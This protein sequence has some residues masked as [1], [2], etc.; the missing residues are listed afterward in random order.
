MTA[1]H[2]WINVPLAMLD[3]TCIPCLLYDVVYR[4]GCVRCSTEKGFSFSPPQWGSHVRHWRD[5]IPNNRNKAGTTPSAVQSAG[6]TSLTVWTSELA[7]VS[8]PA[9]KRS[10][11]KSNAQRTVA[12]QQR[13]SSKLQPDPAN[14][15]PRLESESRNLP[16]ADDKTQKGIF[17]LGAKKSRIRSI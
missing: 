6:R 8:C 7:S 16:F 10:R 4:S 1:G 13:W 5:S 2:G 3:K 12:D 15:S 11:W 17:A 9:K 14:P